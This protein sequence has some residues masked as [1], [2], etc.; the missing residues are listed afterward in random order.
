MAYLGNPPYIQEEM[1]H[2][3]GLR[4]HADLFRSVPEALRLKGDLNVPPM[5]SEMELDRH[6]RRLAARNRPAAQTI[7]FLGAGVYD[8]FIPAAVE[9]LAARGESITPYTPYQAEASQGTLQ[10]LYEYQTMI[11]DL[12]GME[13]ANASLYDGTSAAAEAALMAR[14]I[15][16]RPKVIVSQT[17]HPET[18]ECLKTYL[19]NT[20]AELVTV[21]YREG[22][23]DLE[24]VANVLDDQTACILV[25]LP[26]FFGIV[27]ETDKLVEMAHA[28]GALAVA[29]VN[30]ISMG[31]LRAP[32]EYGVDI[33][34]GEGQPLGI[35]MNMGGPYLGL[36]ATRREFVRQIPGRLAARTVDRRGNESFCLTL[37][38]RE[39]HIRREKATSNICTNEGLMALRAMLYL[40][41]VGAEGLA[42]VARLCAAKAHYLARRLAEVKGFE[43]RYAAPF[44]NEFVL[45]CDQPADRVLARLAKR[46]ICGGVLL[47][48]F[49]PQMDSRILVAVT[50]KRTRDELDAYIEA[51]QQ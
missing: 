45:Q 35:P 26:N 28:I 44:F 11:A 16:R 51:V 5:M 17:V 36:M 27:E 42:E 8:H 37:Q 23:T 13:V 7:S 31:L 15:T 49:Y 4:S 12:Y 48:R 10:T 47:A 29:S 39:Q 2:V 6:V 24:I 21:P 41:L 22:C 19:V 32:G 20:D 33:V 9:L 14:A 18:I 40:S 30:P 25:Q 1:L 50:E 38:T 3:L 43:I 46:G 34:V